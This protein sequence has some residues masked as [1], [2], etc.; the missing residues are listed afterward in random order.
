[1]L[2]V[3]A[4]KNYQSMIDFRLSFNFYKNL[5]TKYLAKLKRWSGKFV[6]SQ[7]HNITSVEKLIA[8]FFKIQSFSSHLNSWPGE[9]ISNN[10]NKNL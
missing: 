6:K 1:M 10:I 8:R 5:S 2:A 4:N 7:H 3:L 9:D